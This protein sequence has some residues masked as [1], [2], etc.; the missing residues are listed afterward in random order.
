MS[1]HPFLDAMVKRRTIYALNKKATISDAR[2]E[3][4]VKHAILHVP[5]SFN[6]QSTRIIVLLKDEH[7]K[8][9]EITKEIMKG[10]LPA[11]KYPATAARLDGFKAGYGTVRPL[12]FSPMSIPHSQLSHDPPPS[13][14]SLLTLFPFD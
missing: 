11:D 12:L 6:S 14:L 13:L 1:A 4:I 2:I 5:S 8:L 3:E 7:D 9:W 10:I